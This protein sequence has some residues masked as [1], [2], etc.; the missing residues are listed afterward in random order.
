M[1]LK[2]LSNFLRT[3]E[4]PLINWEINLILIGSLK[5]AIFEG[6]RVTTFEITDTRLYVPVVSLLTQNN[7]KLL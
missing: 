4:M 2:C 3:I 1:S 6:N 7:T 5:Y